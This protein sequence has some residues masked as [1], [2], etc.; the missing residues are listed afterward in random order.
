MKTSSHSL[1]AYSFWTALGILA[2]IGLLTFQSLRSFEDASRLRIHTYDVLVSINELLLSIV[3]A[4]TGQRGY[5]ITG[6]KEYLDIYSASLLKIRQ[7]YEALQQLTVDNPRQQERLARM[8]PLLEEKLSGL[9][10]RIQLRETHGIDAAARAIITSKD[11]PV[12]DTL[13]SI[14]HDMVLEEQNLLK[15]REASVAL[16]Y[17]KAE[18]TL[19]FGAVSCAGLLFIAF[20]M[21]RR[22][23]EVRQ[24]AEVHVQRLNGE[25]EKNLRDL[26][27]LNKD[28][29]AFNYS[30]SHDLRTPLRAL[31]GYSRELQLN[32]GDRLDPASRNDLTRI[33]AA[34][35]R[36]GQLIDDL[37]NLSRLTR[38]EIRKEDVNLTV[39]AEGVIQEL[40]SAHPGR[41]VDISLAPDIRVHGDR[42]LLTIVL[43]NLLSNAWK[44]TENRPLA[45]I[46]MGVHDQ[47]GTRTVFVKD[48]G[49]G[50]DMAYAGKLFGPFQRLHNAD[51]F[52]GNG[53][54]LSTVQ[55]I[56]HR[57][58]GTLRAEGK[59]DEGA[60]FYFSIP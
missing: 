12:M 33:R 3:N 45:R 18:F 11:K 40:Q 31:D 57:H 20:G 30:V 21:L 49:A 13:R 44:F 32:L 35:T 26:R 41:R 58:G 24:S 23:I 1:A 27:A 17:G 51:E 47:N 55:R 52:P 48:N 15:K 22:E 46:E 36:M 42:K 7:R 34:A 28:L 6:D 56:I 53:I 59:V 9:K 37:L 2:L 50:F 19:L 39:L 54:G 10:Q 16:R 60:S 4:E 14:A 8:G 29:D 43:T 38:A 5:L 25:L